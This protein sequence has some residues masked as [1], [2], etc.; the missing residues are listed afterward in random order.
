MSEIDRNQ[1]IEQ[2]IGVFDE[3]F[4]HPQ[5]P[6]SY[7]TDNVPGAGYDGL[8]ATLTAT[9]A[10]Q[11][12]CNTTIVAHVNH[13]IFALETLTAWIRGERTFRD[14]TSSWN[15][16]KVESEEW[17]RMKS[18]LR[19]S[20][21]EARS[22]LEQSALSSPESFGGAIGMIAHAAYHLS[23]IRHMIKCTDN[24]I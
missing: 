11:T 9:Q 14:W 15:I 22:A 8:L 12:R 17:E 24:D 4:P 3:A 20:Y 2:L 13:M 1:I 16:H 6:W 7:F 23:A 10:S 5:K 21:I 18:R 19:E